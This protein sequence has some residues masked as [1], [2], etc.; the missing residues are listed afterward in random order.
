MEAKKSFKY[1]YTFIRASKDKDLGIT[2]KAFVVQEEA[3]W[4]WVIK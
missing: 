1:K 3:E 2:A 4:Q